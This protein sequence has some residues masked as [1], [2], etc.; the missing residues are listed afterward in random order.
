VKKKRKRRERRQKLRELR[1]RLAET[2]DPTT[3]RRLIEKMKRISR[4]APV[5]E[6]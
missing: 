4:R 5:P 3:R 1:H 6:H 2:Q